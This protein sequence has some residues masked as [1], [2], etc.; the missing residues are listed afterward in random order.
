MSPFITKEGFKSLAVSQE[1]SDSFQG[2]GNSTTLEEKQ[3]IFT[4]YIIK[5]VHP[6]KLSDICFKSDSLLP[7]LS[8]I[9]PFA[10]SP[11]VTDLHFNLLKK[12]KKVAAE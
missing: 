11:L 2:F 6:I 5:F 10:L 12:S 4:Q 3:Q 9:L 7:K 1:K 8:K